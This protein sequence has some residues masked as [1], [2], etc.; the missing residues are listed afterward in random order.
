M[1]QEDHD[2]RNMLKDLLK[3]TWRHSEH[4]W[5]WRHSQYKTGEFWSLNLWNFRKL[6]IFLCE[7]VSWIIII[8]HKISNKLVI[9]LV[10]IISNVFWERSSVIYGDKLSATGSDFIENEECDIANL[11]KV[12]R[13]IYFSHKAFNFVISAFYSPKFRQRILMLNK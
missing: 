9:L 8:N 10:H 13:F 2:F 6:A 5:S 11:S 1:S 3:Q 4:K 12:N 7:Y